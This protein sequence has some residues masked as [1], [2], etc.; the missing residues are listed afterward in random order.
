MNKIFTPKFIIELE[1]PTEM[2][3]KGILKNS[4]VSH[5]LMFWENI[6]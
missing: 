5:A 4:Y 1:V 3:K 6:V 2:L